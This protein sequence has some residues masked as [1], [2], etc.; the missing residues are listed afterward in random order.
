MHP[1]FRLLQ[2]RQSAL[3]LAGLLLTLQVLAGLMI[4][5]GADGPTTSWQTAA[6]CA[7]T[8]VP[9]QVAFESPETGACVTISAPETVVTAAGTEGIPALQSNGMLL[10]SISDIGP[11]PLPAQQVSSLRG[12]PFEV[13]RA[14]RSVVLRI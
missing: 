12:P 7:R 13:D 2:P 3:L 5:P 14:L 11:V 9:Q 1:P 10:S 8:G 4:C 6:R